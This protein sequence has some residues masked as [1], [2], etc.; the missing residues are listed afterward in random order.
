MLA[1]I[2]TYRSR[3]W[4]CSIKKIILKLS[5][6]IKKE[7]P[8]QMF[9]WKLCK[10]FKN[11][12]FTSPDDCSCSTKNES[13][14]NLDPI[15]SFRYKKKELFLKNTS[16]DEV[17]VSLLGIWKIIFGTSDSAKS[18]TFESFTTIGSWKWHASFQCS[19]IKRNPHIFCF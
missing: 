14:D 2:T 5:T 3:H 9:S 12:C 19:K 4:K 16:R 7:T 15:P 18:H 6:L 8:T 10:T 13:L 1:S 17:N 11:T